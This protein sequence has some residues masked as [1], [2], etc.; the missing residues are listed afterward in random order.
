MIDFG[1]SEL[2]VGSRGEEEGETLVED[3]PVDDDMEEE[4]INAQGDDDEDVDVEDEEHEQDEVEEDE[5]AAGDFS[6]GTPVNVSLPRH[7]RNPGQI[8]AHVRRSRPSTGSTPRKLSELAPSP[9]AHSHP[10]AGRPCD[11]NREPTP[12]CSLATRRCPRVLAFRLRPVDL[13]RPVGPSQLRSPRDQARRRNGNTSFR[14][15][16]SRRR[17]MSQNRRRSCPLLFDTSS[18]PLL[19]PR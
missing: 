17:I 8:Y 6:H 2:V 1:G 4:F 12:H 14:R 16:M 13:A 15:T 3:M 10:S 9:D 11:S 5:S 18:M 19:L 7:P